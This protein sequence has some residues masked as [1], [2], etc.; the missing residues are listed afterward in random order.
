[1]KQACLS[2]IRIF[3]LSGRASR[4]DYWLAFG[5]ALAVHLIAG[6]AW[7]AAARMVP[8]SGDS[9]AVPMTAWAL[10]LSTASS[11]SPMQFSL[12]RRRLADATTP[13]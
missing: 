7:L 9:G 3:S 12:L 8:A 11:L 1:M 13:I 10:W 2:A 6:F 5:I 4:G